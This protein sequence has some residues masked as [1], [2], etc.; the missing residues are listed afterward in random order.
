MSI[1]FRTAPTSVNGK[2]LARTGTPPRPWKQAGLVVAGL[3]AMPLLAGPGKLTESAKV[4]DAEKFI[5]RDTDGKARAELGLHAGQPTL[6]LLD[7]K[8]NQRARLVV[9]PDGSAN[10]SLY[11]QNGKL[12]ATLA[13]PPT[14]E[15][16]LVLPDVTAPGLVRAASRRASPD[17][18]SERMQAAQ[19][20]FR[21]LCAT[22]HGSDGKGRKSR[23]RANIPDFTSAVWQEGRTDFQLSASILNGRGDRMPAFEGRVSADQA[24]DLV[25]LIRSFGPASVQRADPSAD[26]FE[27]RFRRLQQDFEKLQ[28]QLRD[29]SSPPSKP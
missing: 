3:A 20:L 7:E 23:A 2:P 9:A 8:G 4:V 13:V 28:K 1:A 26:D 15:P 12:R 17:L 22:C 21:Q 14:G 11:N 24:R 27:A 18:S 10:W 29:V 19:G 6:A 5:L 16:R 25:A